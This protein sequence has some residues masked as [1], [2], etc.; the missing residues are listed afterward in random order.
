M[1]QIPAEF[2][3]LIRLV[4]YLIPTLIGLTIFAVQRF[5]AGTD[6]QEFEQRRTELVGDRTHSVRAEIEDLARLAAPTASRPAAS[7]TAHGKRGSKSI[8]PARNRKAS[9]TSRALPVNGTATLSPATAAGRAVKAGGS[10]TRG[11]TGR[12][13]AAKGGRGSRSKRRQERAFV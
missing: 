6:W 7:A 12:T 4:S 11:A 10:Q 2:H 13:E 8:D 5:H 9:G 3:G 1:S